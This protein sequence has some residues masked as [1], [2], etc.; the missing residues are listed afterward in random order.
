M[1]FTTLSC[2]QVREVDEWK[3]EPEEDGEEGRMTD[4]VSLGA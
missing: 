1:L 4:T 3:Q 2:R